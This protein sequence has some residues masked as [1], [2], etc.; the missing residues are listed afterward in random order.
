MGQQF[1]IKD[2]ETIRLARELAEASG[3]TITATIRRALEREHRE[4]HAKVQE[5]LDRIREMT[6]DFRADLSPELAGKASRNIVQDFHEQEW[7]EQNGHDEW[8]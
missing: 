5:V 2:A 4:R 8:S 3:E 1:N 6:A 7:Q